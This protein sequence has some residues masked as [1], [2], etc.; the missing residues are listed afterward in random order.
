MNEDDMEEMIRQYRDAHRSHQ[1][2]QYRAV[3]LQM[4]RECAEEH[5]ALLK[6]W[7]KREL[8]F[9]CGSIACGLLGCMSGIL[10]DWYTPLIWTVPAVQMLCYARNLRGIKETLAA[11]WLEM[12]QN[13]L[14]WANNYS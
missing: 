7:E 10:F 3:W 14:D 2:A 11:P 12:R 5:G 4:A 6:R 13:R 1:N 9:L 8:G